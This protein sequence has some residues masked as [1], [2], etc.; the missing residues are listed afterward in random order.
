M[1][2]DKIHGRP[3]ENGSP[4]GLPHKAAC[5]EDV[6]GASSVAFSYFAPHA[7]PFLALLLVLAI[8]QILDL[9]RP[10]VYLVQTL[11]VAGLLL[12]FRRAYRSEIRVAFDGAAVAA[13]VFVFVVWVAMEGMYPLL[14]PSGGVSYA[15]ASASDIAVRLLGAALVVPLAEELFWRSFVMRI[16]IR[17]DFKAVQ[18]G[19]F[20]RLSFV[21]T[22]L[23]FGF[24][25]HR[26]LPG[27]VAGIVYA[28]LLYR[29]K[30]LFSPILSHAVTNAFLGVYVI[31]TGNWH[32]W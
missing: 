14:D 11:I 21:F 23:A 3:G 19:T 31:I 12:H 7:A 13:G 29:S 28:V 1:S 8:G 24:E 10:A 18:L 17:T 20:T 25:P 9:S 5:A 6:T 27:I 4:G 22:V 2:A 30:N 32:F 26:W 15:A 16:L